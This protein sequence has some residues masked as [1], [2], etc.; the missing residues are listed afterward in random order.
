MMYLGIEGSTLPKSRICFAD[1]NLATDS[2][3][4]PCTI[5]CPAGSI[6]DVLPV[7]PVKAVPSA[8]VNDYIIH[9]SSHCHSSGLS[10]R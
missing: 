2:P 1:H 3:V 10:I 8:A 5:C 7:S 9:S 6:V 4:L